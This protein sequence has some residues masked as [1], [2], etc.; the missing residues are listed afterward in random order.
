MVAAPPRTAP[1]SSHPG[2]MS[3]CPQAR[4][5]TPSPDDGVYHQSPL[6]L[7]PEEHVMAPH[8]GHR[9]GTAS[10]PSRALLV[11]PQHPPTATSL[12][13]VIPPALAELV[14]AA[15]P[16]HAREVPHLHMQ[17]TTTT[18]SINIYITYIWTDISKNNIKSKNIHNTKCTSMVENLPRR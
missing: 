13:A 17:K 6:R 10:L 7:P 4:P 11:D 12:P 14:L 9:T 18:D 1:G 16:P 8:Q 15:S 2:S 5:A 3:T